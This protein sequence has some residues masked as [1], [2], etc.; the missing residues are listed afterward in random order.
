MKASLWKIYYS[1]R[2]SLY[3]GQILKL[4]AIRKFYW[5]YSGNKNRNKNRWQSQNT[6]CAL[7][8]INGHSYAFT[9]IRFL[10][11]PTIK[12]YSIFTK[13]SL[14]G[15]FSFLKSNILKDNIEQTKVTCIS[16][17]LFPQ[18]HPIGIVRLSKIYDSSLIQRI[19]HPAHLFCNL[20]LASKKILIFHKLP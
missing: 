15:P 17:A 8:M 1:V 2:T 18:I 7:N 16:S 3:L 14:N 10:L 4:H 11:P 12:F 5:V 13:I 9:S 19:L 20:T 6:G